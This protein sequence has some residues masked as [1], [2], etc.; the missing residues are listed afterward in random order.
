[1][2]VS[3]WGKADSYSGTGT[4]WW[5]VCSF[6]CNDNTS[7]HIYCV[8][9]ARYKIEYKPELNAYCDTS[10]WRH[11]TY[12]LDGTTII[13]YIDGEQVGKATTENA[14]RLLKTMT[15]GHNKVCIN[16]FRIYDHALSVKEVKEIA[17]GLI[18]HMP[19]DNNGMGGVNL[20]KGGYSVTSTKNGHTTSGSLSFDTSIMPLSDLIG[21]TIVFSFDYKCDGPKLNATGDYT[22]DRYGFHLSM[23]YTDASGKAGTAY[24]CASVLEPVGIGRAV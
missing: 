8:P 7:F 10:V 9:N 6:T 17:K 23:T 14:D 15:I 22:K 16:D 12:V 4:Q 5:Q 20:L 18:L 1:M 3:F 2:S 21:K 19:L 11:I 24:P 13:A